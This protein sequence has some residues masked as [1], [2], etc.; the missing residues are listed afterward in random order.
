MAK[1]TPE[2]LKEQRRRH[3]LKYIHRWRSGGIYALAENL[4]R[5]AKRENLCIRRVMATSEIEKFLRQ[6]EKETGRG[7]IRGV[8][9]GF[10]RGPKAARRRGR[11][12]HPELRRFE[13]VRRKADKIRATP[14]WADMVKIRKIYRE[15]R[16]VG[17]TVDH[18][19]P[20][21]SPIVCGFHCEANLQILTNDENGK[22]ANR[23]WP[24]M[25]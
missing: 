22:K 18:I 16:L 5:R 25:P 9:D 15:A 14:K 4:Q 3:Y 12:R 2:Q 13:K 10:G 8:V 1:G 21:R 17:L 7:W 19:V 23:T 24:D 11:L 20:L 6:M